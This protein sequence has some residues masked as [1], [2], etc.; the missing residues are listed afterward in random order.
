M[1]GGGGA[2][3]VEKVREKDGELAT[4]MRTAGDEKRRLREEIGARRKDEG[5]PSEG[6]ETE[7]TE[8]QGRRDWRRAEVE[9]G[10]RERRDGRCGGGGCGEEGCWSEGGVLGR[11]R[12]RRGRENEPDDYMMVELGPR[13]IG[14]VDCGEPTIG[15]TFQ[16][17]TVKK[18]LA[19]VW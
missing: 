2:G 4:E 9:R 8:E 7:T 12:T 1:R 15:M 18:A 11:W 19:S 6:G 13:F 10:L 14:A 16:V 3:K 17:A 5:E